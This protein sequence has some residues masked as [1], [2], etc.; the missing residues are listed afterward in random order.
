MEID[1]SWTLSSH[2]GQE[3]VKEL[4]HTSNRCLFSPD[5]KIFVRC[6]PSSIDFISSEKKGSVAPPTSSSEKITCISTAFLSPWILC[7]GTSLGKLIF[8][9]QNGKV[10]Y[11]QTPIKNSEIL[12]IRVCSFNESHF[13]QPF[14]VIYIQYNDSVAVT[15]Q[16]D[17]IHQKIQGNDKVEVVLKFWQIN[18]KNIQDAV[19]V[20]SNLPSPIFSGLHRFPAIFT[21]GANPFLSVSSILKPQPLHTVEKVKKLASK[22]YGYITGVQKEEEEPE[23]SKANFEWDLSDEGR[24]GNSIS[25]DPTGRWLAICDNKSRVIIID[26]VFGHITRVIKGYRDAQIAWYTSISPKSEGNKNNIQTFLVIYGPYRKIIFV[27]SMPSGQIIDAVKVGSNGKLFQT[28]NLFDENNHLVNFGVNYIYPDGKVIQLKISPKPI[29]KDD[30]DNEI[31]APFDHFSLPNF[32]TVEGHPL[33]KELLTLL[34]N[35]DLNTS[36]IKALASK[37]DDYAVGAAFIVYLSRKD[38]IDDS[39]LLEI[40]NSICEKLNIN[41]FE[42]SSAEYF[43]THETSKTQFDEKFELTVYKHL[44]KRWFEFSKFE[45]LTVEEFPQTSLTESFGEGVSKL[46]IQSD[47]PSLK[48]FLLAP[49]KVPLFFFFFLKSST[50]T[51]NDIYDSYRLCR[52]E[53]TEFIFQLLIWVLTA[54]PA[55]ILIAQEALGD[56]FSLKEINAAAHKAKSQLLTKTHTV[57]DIAVSFFLDKF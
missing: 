30:N 29:E 48:L 8:F 31:I 9:D 41:D 3:N 12:F 56:F 25:P 21:V 52:D 14:P 15:I 45:Q 54:Q 5:G 7:V 50:N 10:Y 38:N 28:S 1:S 32:I 49:L 6:G 20:N 42:T 22:F 51:L 53:K 55:Q 13:T 18:H 47:I 46:I 34:Q 26:A 4:F 23:I 44:A 43:A 19:V 40:V 24:E 33:I 27:C 35:E 37:I 57:N 2:L 36:P 39:F 16:R 11:E 17:M